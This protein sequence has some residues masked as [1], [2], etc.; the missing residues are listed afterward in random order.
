MIDKTVLNDGVEFTDTNHVG[1][2]S[3]PI[4]YQAMGI[5]RAVRPCDVLE[6]GIKSR[7]FL[8]ANGLCNFNEL[9]SPEQLRSFDEE[10]HLFKR[11]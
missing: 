1:L 7:V 4:G 2:S 8:Q 5:A 6:V 10:L 9:P 3:T 11:R